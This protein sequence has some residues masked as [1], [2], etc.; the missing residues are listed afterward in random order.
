MQVPTKDHSSFK[1]RETFLVHAA[2][3]MS[4]KALQNPKENIATF[5]ATTLAF[6]VIC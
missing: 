5:R 1:G 6:L 4:L 3:L 2:S